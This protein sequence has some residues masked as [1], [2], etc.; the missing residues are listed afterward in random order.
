MADNCKLCRIALENVS[1]VRGGQTLLQDVSMHIHC[2]QL[3]VLIGQNGAGKTTLIRALLGEYA[4]GGTIRHVDGEG[5][6]VAHMRTGYVPQH[7]EFDKEMPVTVEDFLAA[8]L[9]RRPV[10][11]L[12]LSGCGNT[13]KSAVAAASSTSASETS[14]EAGKGSKVSQPAENVDAQVAEASLPQP[15]EAIS[16]SLTWKS[17]MELAYATQ[18]AVDIYEDADGMQYEAVSVADGSRFLLIPEGGKVPED[19]PDSIQVLKRPV[20]QIYL[21]ATATMDMFRMLG[22]LPDIRFS[23]T[24]ASGWYIPEAKEAMENGSILYAGK[25]SEP[26]YERI[27]SEGCGLA[28]ENTMILH[29]PEV[30]EKLESFG[31][32]VIVDHSSY[33][34]HPLGRTEW[35]RLYGV[36]TGKEKEAE[37]AFAKQEAALQR[38]TEEGSDA[39]NAGGSV[40]TEQTAQAEKP[41]AAFFYITNQGSV[42]VR[43]SSDYIP[44]MIELAGGRYIFGH[45]GDDGKRSS[46]VNMQME[47][48]YAA[49][50]ESDYLIYNSTIDGEI[51]SISELLAK[52]P[53]L[54]DFK[55]VQAGNVW[56]TTKNLYQESM[57]VGA[58]LEDIHAIFSGSQ[59]DGTYLYKLQS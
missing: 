32:P 39:E 15:G 29:S 16:A 33:E 14:N 51:H 44:K 55:A 47:E 13:G 34:A 58:M 1:V 36:L 21:V 23:G 41:S 25:Y 52:A 19:L 6:D 57:S 28:I 22:A 10:W 31:I 3:T 30:K 42:N 12:L 43:R 48:F 59:E 24:D 38:V 27:V 2:G 53:V 20:K 11:M 56:C 45:L 4:H 17:R 26:D 9:T 40:K 49:A 37:A 54:K 7:L 18:F 50:K 5:R 8:S 35:I 46:T